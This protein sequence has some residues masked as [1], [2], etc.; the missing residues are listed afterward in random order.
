MCVIIWPASSDVGE[1]L[2]GGVEGP[3]RMPIEKERLS[4]S[5]AVPR[6]VV[7][8]HRARYAFAARLVAGKRVVDCAC[9]DGF[10]TADFASAGSRQIVAIDASVDAVIAARRAGAGVTRGVLADATRLPLASNWADVF[11][12]LETL[13]HVDEGERLLDEA[14]RVL[15]RAG[16]F[17]CS[18]PNRIVTHPG[19]PLT[20]RP[21]SRF[22]AR[23]YA[24]EEFRQLLAARFEQVELFG[25]NPQ[26]RIQARAF[27]MIARVLPFRTIARLNQLV[28]LRRLVRY[29]DAECRVTPLDTR[30]DYEYIVAVGSR[31]RR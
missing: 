7:A 9:G 22:H 21:I 1:P 14:A 2:L 4:T 25:Q 28:K 18:T 12:C 16:T 29:V 17:V 6:W 10:G 23:E 11:I 27:A 20:T 5:N 26:P 19:A 13:E 8:E 15:T 3:F 24:V 30:A 31:P